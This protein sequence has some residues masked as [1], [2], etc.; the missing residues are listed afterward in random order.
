MCPILPPCPADATVDHS[1]SMAIQKARLDKKMT[2]KELA[3]AIAEKPTIIGEYESGRAIP[4]PTL[5]SKLERALGV[6]LPRPAKKK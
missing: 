2:Q 4:N 3:A 1:L 6:R 5:I